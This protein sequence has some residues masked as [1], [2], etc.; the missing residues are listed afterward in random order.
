MELRPGAGYPL[1]MP[2]VDDIYQALRGVIDPELGGNLVDL[3]MVG[4]VDIDPDGIVSIGLALTVA[5]CPMR[6]HLEG[7]TSRRIAGLPGVKD[8]VV[9]TTAMTKDQRANLMTGARL[10]ARENAAPTKVHPTTR[11]VAVSSGKG[12]VGKSTVS[13]NLAVALA[14]QGFRVGLLDAD[15]WGFSIPRML[16]VEDR[17]VADQDT[18]LII[19][20]EVDGIKLVS[21]GLIIDSEETALMWRGLMLSK[22]LEQFL[23]QVQWGDLDYLVIDMPPGNRRHPN[24]AVETSPAGRDGGRDHTAEGRPEGGDPGRRHGPPIPHAPGR[25]HREHVVLHLRSR[26]RVRLVRRGWRR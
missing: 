21:T 17:L 9:H 2:K 24:G 12:G 1:C 4:S 16:G 11:V 15:I 3:G 18:K 10:R 20:I 8:V 23:N 19:P 22:A 14:D 26:H 6:N 13:V 25:R 5:E 7:E